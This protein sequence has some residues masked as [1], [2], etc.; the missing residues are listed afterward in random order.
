VTD[1]PAE[2][3]YAAIRAAPDD[4]LPRLVFADWL[5]EHDQPEQAEYIRLTCAAAR[6]PDGERKRVVQARADELFRAHRDEWFGPLLATFKHHRIDRGFITSIAAGSPIPLAAHDRELTRFAPCL[7]Q[8][9]TA[10]IGADA[11]VVLALEVAR[12]VTHLLLNRVAPVSLDSLAAHVELPNLTELYVWTNGLHRLSEGVRFTEWGLLRTVPA[13]QLS[14]GFGATGGSDPSLVRMTP[15]REL[16]ERH[17]DLPNLRAFRLW[18][19]T[20]PIALALT[21][22]PR[23]Q[24][25]VELNLHNCCVAEDALPILLPELRSANLQ[26]LRLNSNVLSDDAAAEIADH[27]LPPSL[28]ELHLDR[29]RIGDRGAAALIASPNLP[30]DLVLHIGNNTFSGRSAASLRERFPNVRF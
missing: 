10:G 9:V 13:L 27:R 17:L 5:E 2:P 6:E 22:W 21:R 25:L 28:R 20:E 23:L 18:G 14:I 12:R 19:I 26:V 3:F 1:D 30:H 24:Q 7:A 15:T 11:G 16:L 8:L 29:N 4:D